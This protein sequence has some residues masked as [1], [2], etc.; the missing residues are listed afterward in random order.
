MQSVVSSKIEQESCRRQPLAATQFIVAPIVLLLACIAAYGGALAVAFSSDDFEYLTIFARIC[1]GDLTLFWTNVS[2]C[3]LGNPL[4]GL[5]FRPLLQMAFLPDFLLWG[6]RPQG[7]HLTNLSLHWICSVM[8]YVSGCQLLNSFFGGPSSVNGRVTPQRGMLC[9]PALAAATIFAVSPVHA[10]VTNWLA[11]RVDSFCTFWLLSAF[12][13][14]A[15]ASNASFPGIKERSIFY[16]KIAAAAL[17]VAALCSKESAVIL[18]AVLL[19]F[20]VIIGRSWKNAAVAT[21]PFWSIL[22]VFMFVRFLALGQAVGGYSSVIDGLTP[23]MV[24]N[25]FTPN[26]LKYCFISVPSDTLAQVKPYAIALGAG[27][28]GALA[29]CLIAQSRTKFSDPSA[30]LFWFLCIWLVLSLLPIAPFFMPHQDMLGNRWLYAPTSVFSLLLMCC[31]LSPENGGQRDR[32]KAL[33]ILPLLLIP[34]AQIPLS[35]HNTGLWQRGAD[36]CNSVAS[37]LTSYAKE[38][39]GQPIV[40]TSIPS[41]IDGVHTFYLLR[42]MRLATSRN[43]VP[44][45]LTVEQADQIRFLEPNWYIENGI[46]N[47]SSLLRL[48][49]HPDTRLCS[50]SMNL[51]GEAKVSDVILKSPGKGE[52]SLVFDEKQKQTRFLDNMQHIT[53][54]LPTPVNPAQYPLLSLEFYGDLPDVSGYLYVKTPVM[55]DFD[56]AASHGFRPVIVGNRMLISTGE[57]RPWLLAGA[58]DKVCI[59]LPT[60]RTGGFKLVNAQLLNDRAYVPLLGPGATLSLRADAVYER[61][62]GNPNSKLRF[63]V[64]GISGATHVEVEVCRELSRFIYATGTYRD[65][66]RASK[67]WKRFTVDRVSG[68][69]DLP[70]EAKAPLSRQ[71]WHAVR[72]FAVDGA[73]RVIGASSDPIYVSLS[74]ASHE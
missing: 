65:T 72:I 67:V 34:L 63:D 28:V 3:F 37:A 66:Q 62:P 69:F 27:Y 57:I 32:W 18:P 2:G 25:F 56:V 53:L 17:F 64:S 14:Y 59:S 40:L 33:K 55:K 1:S 15:S 70:A 51:D 73:N 74:E 24:L 35:Q 7:W 36:F 61:K 13:C 44:N 19:A 29:V 4:Y 52:G 60:W 20:E 6:F 42:T 41:R 23:F 48:A 50:I 38:R 54:S 46:V 22:G 58:V 5:H 47:R 71:Y 12:C 39:P 31:A 68:E 49:D 9:W 10:E 8:V 26:A 21:L 45:G 11:A 43:F 16:R 30:R